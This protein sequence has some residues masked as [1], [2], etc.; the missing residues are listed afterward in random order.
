MSIVGVW[1]C[2]LGTVY[3]L[4]SILNTLIKIYL[5]IDEEKENKKEIPEEIK[6]S[7]YS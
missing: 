1:A 2:I 6:R 5:I 4:N 3:V 7:L